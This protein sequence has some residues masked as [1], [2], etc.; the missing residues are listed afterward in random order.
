[1]NDA[2][3]KTQCMGLH[4]VLSDVDYHDV[5]GVDLFPELK[6]LGEIILKAQAVHFKPF[7]V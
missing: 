4:N 1:M 7:S 6:M 3:L 5:N 2:D